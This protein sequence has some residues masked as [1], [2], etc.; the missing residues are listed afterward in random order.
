MN[1]YRVFSGLDAFEV[2]VNGTVI[3]LP[4]FDVIANNEENARQHVAL[5][6]NQKLEDQET[7]FSYSN[8]ISKHVEFISTF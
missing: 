2:N 1:I 7:N 5:L 4:Y 6:I 8:Y 3:Y